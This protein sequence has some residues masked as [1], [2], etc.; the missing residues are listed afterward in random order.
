MKKVLV[1]GTYDILHDGH[2]N[3]F[4]QAKRHGD[5]LT[6]VISRDKTVK[7][8]KGEEPWNSEEERRRRVEE[9]ELVDEAV[10]GYEGDKYRIVEEVNPDVICLGYDQKAFTKDL[11]EK[12][13]NRGLDVEVKRM[14]AY[15]PE[16]YKSSKIKEE[17]KR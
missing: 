6:V 4:Q 14:E 12:L 9:C 15:K 7:E 8:I 10:L 13:R 1:T 2:R 5:H 17:L 16:K 11:K 3:F